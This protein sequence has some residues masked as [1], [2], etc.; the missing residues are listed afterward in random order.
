MIRFSFF[1]IKLMLFN[2]RFGIASTPATT[3]AQQEEQNL[4]E[5]I[6]QADS[7]LDRWFEDRSC[8][9]RVANGET[10]SVVSVFCCFVECYANR[11]V[12]S[13]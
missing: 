10:E 13:F 5:L 2:P 11:S 9:L 8:G 4:D 12:T 7:E 1:S 3:P 6:R